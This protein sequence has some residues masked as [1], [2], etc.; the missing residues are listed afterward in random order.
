MASPPSLSSAVLRYLEATTTSITNIG[1][2]RIIV[3]MP[4]HPSEEEAPPGI[5]DQI[6]KDPASA[7]QSTA[8]DHPLHQ[9]DKAESGKATAQDFQSK[10]PA[11]PQ[12]MNGKW[13]RETTAGFEEIL[14][15]LTS[16][17]YRH[18]SQRVQGSSE[19]SLGGVEQV[20]WH[21]RR[22]AVSCLLLSTST[23]HLTRTT[24]GGARRRFHAPLGSFPGLLA[25]SC[26]D[27]R[28]RST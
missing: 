24:Q 4:V 9:G 13:H 10:G 19:G 27:A 11:M 14:H 16:V 7:T 12:N 22:Y 26:I 5:F 21:S 3:T 23:N 15:V 25:S 8:S 18:A 28:V 20:K 17:G 6:A 2:A 1:T